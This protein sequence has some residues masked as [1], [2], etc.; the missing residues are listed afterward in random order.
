MTKN[1]NFIISI[2]KSIR[3]LYIN[4]YLI[5]FKEKIILVQK[6]LVNL[7]IHNYKKLIY[8]SDK[9]ITNYGHNFKKRLKNIRWNLFFSISLFIGNNCSIFYKKIALKGVGY[10]FIVK[11]KNKSVL[12]MVLGYSHPIY[13]RLPKEFKIFLIKPTLLYITCT[14]YL[15]LTLIS[16]RLKLLKFPDVYK[17]KGIN[18]EYE[19]TSLKLGKKAH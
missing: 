18:I 2:P 4:N 3:L 16:Q 8:I 10:R 15:K 17:G 6:L 5:I 19:K 12:Q 9:S 1:F 11:D 14:N 7:L 13:I